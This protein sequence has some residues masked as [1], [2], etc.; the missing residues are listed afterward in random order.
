MFSLTDITNVIVRRTQKFEI[1]KLFARKACTVEPIIQT[2][3]NI[4]KY[5]VAEIEKNPRCV[6]RVPIVKR[7]GLFF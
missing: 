5:A 7:G 1:S 4:F 6:D 2:L 3:L